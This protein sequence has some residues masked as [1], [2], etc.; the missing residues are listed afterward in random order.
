M[1]NY[2]KEFY[3][4]R[5][6]FEVKPTQNPFLEEGLDPFE[7]IDV[8]WFRMGTI[9]GLG[10]FT[11]FGGVVLDAKIQMGPTYPNLDRVDHLELS[12]FEKPDEISM[13]VD[14]NR[15]LRFFGET[16][17]VWS[18]RAN[19]T[20]HFINTLEDIVNGNE[21]VYNKVL[22]IL[23]EGSDLARFPLNIHGH[24]TERNGARFI[25]PQYETDSFPLDV[26]LFNLAKVLRSIGAPV[27]DGLY[28][29]YS[30]VILHSCNERELQISQK[31]IN[32]LKVPVLY[33]EG[34]LVE[35]IIGTSKNNSKPVLALPE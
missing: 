3:P 4:Q 30:M 6:F 32:A 24:G 21:E 23:K 31:I 33:S 27:S 18:S 14:V 8:R 28:S 1:I 35:G 11:L 19:R 7:G 20:L 25:G 16:Q 26:F 34:I 22:E 9:S 2:G 15:N 5:A 13:P 29:R 10:M 17:G 12:P